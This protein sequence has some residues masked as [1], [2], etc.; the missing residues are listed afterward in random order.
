MCENLTH[1]SDAETAG[2]TLLSRPFCLTYAMQ[3][4]LRILLTQA[5]GHVAV[6]KVSCDKVRKEM[7][8]P[9]VILQKLAACVCCLSSRWQV[10][11]TRAV[12]A[13]TQS[14]SSQTVGTGHQWCSAHCLCNCT[15]SSSMICDEHSHIM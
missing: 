7:P 8:H 12:E 9:P 3:Q 11:N 5:H 13:L 1:P 4:H 6:V 10:T 14:C 2:Y 15:A